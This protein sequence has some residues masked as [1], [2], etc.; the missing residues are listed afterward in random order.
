MDV[1]VSLV[2]V[3]VSQSTQRSNDHV[4][5]LKYTIFIVKGTS[6]NLEKI[7]QNR[8]PLLSDA[9]RREPWVGVGVLIPTILACDL[10]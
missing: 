6:I 2:V 3:I 10:G 9:N 4:L 1:S 5:P 8:R 7:K